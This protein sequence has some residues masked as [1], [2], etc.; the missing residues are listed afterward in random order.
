MSS[1]TQTSSTFAQG[2]HSCLFSHTAPE[3]F[4]QKLRVPILFFPFRCD[5]PSSLCSSI[6]C[7]SVFNPCTVLMYRSSLK[8]VSLW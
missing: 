5:Q 2:V 3:G 8:L 1:T 6:V 7:I 4:L